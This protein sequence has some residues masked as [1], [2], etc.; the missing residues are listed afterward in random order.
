[1]ISIQPTDVDSRDSVLEVVRSAFSD[2]TRD[3]EEEVE[4]VRKTWSAES[5]I[6]VFDFVAI[7]ESEVV[8]HVLAAEGSLAGTSAIGI[9]PV[10]VRPDR[11]GQGIGTALME[12]LLA[13]I[14]NS[15]WPFALLLGNPDYYGRFGF[16]SASQFDIRYAP[17]GVH[18]AFQIRTFRDNAVEHGGHFEYCFE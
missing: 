13:E 8:G 10:C 3:G 14:R 2:D 18:P 5:S 7:L 16:E 12:R 1:M 17:V 6:S 15:G 4:I 9:A 11:Q